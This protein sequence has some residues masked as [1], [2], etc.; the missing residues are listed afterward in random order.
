MLGTPRRPSDC[1]EAN[2]LSG[3]LFCHEC[4]RKMYN[5]RTAKTHYTEQRLGKEY[6]HKVADFYTCSTYS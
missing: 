3:L 6:T 5:S 4:G 1:G 2:P